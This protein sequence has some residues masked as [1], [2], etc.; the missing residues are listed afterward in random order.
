MLSMSFA[1]CLSHFV[2]KNSLDFYPL[3]PSLLY[4]SLSRFFSLSSFICLAQVNNLDTK[5][6]KI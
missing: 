2:T 5:I 4:H 1:F 3:A 6:N